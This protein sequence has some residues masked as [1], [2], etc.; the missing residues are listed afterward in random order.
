[1]NGNTVQVRL[2]G[3]VDVTID[4]TARPVSGARRKTVLAVLGLH[5]GEPVSTDRLADLLWGERPPPTA[6]N[7]LQ[8]HMSYL[9]R[10]L[11]AKTAIVSQTPG[12]LLDIPAEATDLAMARQLI[13]RGDRDTDPTDSAAHLRAALDLWR[14]P[15]LCDVTG[16]AWLDE[17]ARHLD[18]LRLRAVKGLIEARMTLG[19][20]AQLFPELEHLAEQHPY[21]ERLHRQLMLALY[22]SGRHADALAV[23]QHLRHTIGAELGIDPSP[24]LRELEAAILRHD[25][26]LDPPPPAIA[27]A[28]AGWVGPAQL[29]V[30]VRAFV[31]RHTEL[32]RLDALL[33]H[34]HDVPAG[35]SATTTIA[36]VS[37]T[38][39]VGKTTLAV[40]WAH[41]VAGHFP[42]GQLYVNLRGFDPGGSALD[43]AEALRGFLDALAVPAERIPVGLAAQ[44]GLYRSLLA[45][46]RV[47]VVLDNARDVEQVRP[48]LPGAPGCLAIV[49]SRSH[50]TPLVATEGA[51]PLV[52]DLLSPAD[53]Y[54]LLARRLG[55]QRIAAEPDAVQEIITRCARL[56]L[57]L[58]IAAARAATYPGFPLATLAAELPGPA[59]GLDA[60]HGGDPATDIRAVFS[61]SYQTLSTEAAGMFRLLGLHPGPEVTAPAVAS[62]AGLASPTARTLLTELTRAHLLTE[63]TPGRYSFHDL[64]RAYATEQTHTHD[65]PET[66]HAALHR[67]LDHYL[68]TAYTAALLLNPA[69]DPIILGQLQPGVFLEDLDRDSAA[70]WFATERRVLLAASEQAY[71]TGFDTH[72]WQLAWALNTFLFRQGY[73]HEQITVHRTG[74][75]AAKRLGD[76]SAQAYLSRYL[77]QAHIRLGRLDE[78]RH[79]YQQSRQLHA[80]LGDPAGQ[81]NAHSGLAQ[82]AQH[83]GRLADVL[84]HTQ[85][86]L[87][88]HR[89]AGHRIGEANALNG[90]GWSYALLGDYHRAITHCQQALTLLQDL[91]DRATE[92]ATWDSLA[93][94]HR[95]LADHAQ[96]ARCYQ[97]AIDLY[98]TLDDPYEEALAL[99]SLGDTHHTAGDPDAAQTAWR[100]ALDIFTDLGH[101][102]ADTL[103]AKLKSPNISTDGG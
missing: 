40:N 73:W 49:T 86:A 41:R 85:H 47:L 81:A 55:T 10:V 99:A 48:L 76:R 94:A 67:M 31:G 34:R 38:A 89:T 37:G 53:A 29:P 70:D 24:A 80:D 15:S 22:R 82:I 8:S 92:A 39:G 20:H 56:P 25:A 61:W 65:S 45:G 32:D 50:L 66:R 30:A 51:H 97:H 5:P 62:L 9:R 103:H 98:R 36:T 71:A 44:I 42:D 11:G 54:D 77:A 2:L 102:D 57:A 12:Y 72:T 60:L 59:T 35:R 6:S 100:Q 84:S 13:E 23:Y 78:A 83:Q 63:H 18:D 3:P 101:P 16:V 93:F 19:E 28:P 26:A 21:D 46:K 7:T 27:V 90:V 79:Y 33:A 96:S 64:L 14:G 91:N 87:D 17:H 75:Q 4:G 52:L 43:P 1:M 74:L 58:A 68:H 88:L 95:G 69:R